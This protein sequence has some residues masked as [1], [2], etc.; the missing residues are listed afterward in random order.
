MI[1]LGTINAVLNT[2]LE[3]SAPAALDS[4]S[5]AAGAEE[6]HHHH[7]HTALIVLA[8]SGQL[9]ASASTLPPSQ[10]F[11]S[12]SSPPSNNGLFISHGPAPNAL[13]PQLDEKAQEDLASASTPAH[14]LPSLS[15]EE[16]GRVLGGMATLA[17]RENLMSEQPNVPLVF[18]SPLGL[19]L[20]QPLGPGGATPSFSS[21]P[22]SPPQ[23]H[24][25]DEPPLS[26]SLSSNATEHPFQQAPAP[27]TPSA[28]GISPTAL[29]QQQ[30]K[31]AASLRNS[32]L[33]L[34][35]NSAIETGKSAS[36][37]VAIG[38]ADAKEAHEETSP[39]RQQQP[40]EGSIAEAGAESKATLVE[41]GTGGT[42]DNASE[43]VAHALQVD[44]EALTS[45]ASAGVQFLS[46]ALASVS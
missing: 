29:H 42:G 39:S 8:H 45:I 11:A 23:Q 2:L 21:A 44:T 30:R 32:R 15:G 31:R 19:I 34:V 24:Y 7:P 46:P 5:P 12:T 6:Q 9:Y 16:R 27:S 25:H 3:P 4:S 41:T 40:S 38:D 36:K 43:A 26:P 35:L 22:N 33:L 14:I 1:R 37:G 17:W 13:S 28:E 20:V 10:A 18:E